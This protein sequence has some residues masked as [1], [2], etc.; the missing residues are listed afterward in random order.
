[1]M[2][3]DSLPAGGMLDMERNLRGGEPGVS[4]FAVFMSSGP[5]LAGIGRGDDFVFAPAISGFQEGIADHEHVERGVFFEF[6]KMSGQFE[7]FIVT[8]EIEAVFSPV[9]FKAVHGAGASRIDGGIAPDIFLVRRHI[10]GETGTDV[11]RKIFDSF[12]DQFRGDGGHR[13]FGIADGEDRKMEF[14]DEFVCGVVCEGCAPLDVI[15]VQFGGDGDGDGNCA[16]LFAF[17]LGIGEG[18][19]VFFQLDFRFSCGTCLQFQASG[20]SED[21]AEQFV[22]TEEFSA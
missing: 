17:T 8:A 12:A 6:E 4:P 13:R 7:G 19:P 15:V 3:N 16:S 18:D 1:M 10:I 2:Q 21:H 14:A 20:I 22:R 11:L 5:P 9:E